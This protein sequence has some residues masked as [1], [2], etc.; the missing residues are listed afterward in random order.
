MAVLAKFGRRAYRLG[1]VLLVRQR[2]K[3][4]PIDA[5]RIVAGRQMRQFISSRNKS[6]IMLI[7]P[8]VGVDDSSVPAAFSEMTVPVLVL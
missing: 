2:T 1:T 8:D 4:L 5:G 7:R 3:V 6:D